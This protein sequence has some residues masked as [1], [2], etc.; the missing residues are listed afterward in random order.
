MKSTAQAR[1]SPRWFGVQGLIQRIRPTRALI[2]GVP[3]WLAELVYA[4]PVSGPWYSWKESSAL[5]AS[6]AP[7]H[8]GGPIRA[9]G[10]FAERSHAD[11]LNDSS[12][13][14]MTTNKPKTRTQSPDRSTR[15]RHPCGNRARSGRP[16][17]RRIKKVVDRTQFPRDDS[18]SQMIPN[19]TLTA[20]PRRQTDARANPIEANGPAARILQP[21][22]GEGGL[23][24]AD[25]DRRGPEVRG[26]FK[27]MVDRTQSRNGTSK[28]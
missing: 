21:P 12:S 28:R 8:R 3:G 11:I 19:K 13:N 23:E 10:F 4:N 14:A 24:S 5:M 17:A 27:K 20:N 15:P 7:G 22:R 16:S 18:A 1:I 25:D 9:P 2:P 6:R 26:G